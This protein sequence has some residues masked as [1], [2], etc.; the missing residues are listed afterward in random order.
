MTIIRDR[1]CWIT[2]DAQLWQTEDLIG[3]TININ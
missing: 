2:T 1:E 3:L